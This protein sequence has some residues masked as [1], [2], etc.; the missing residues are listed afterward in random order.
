MEGGG[1]NGSDCKYVKP[2]AENPSMEVCVY[3]NTLNEKL[4]EVNL[5]GK[6]LVFPV[7]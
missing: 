7:L 1:K 6:M 5:Y 4:L 3:I 2:G